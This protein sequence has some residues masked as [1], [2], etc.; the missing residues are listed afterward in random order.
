MWEIKTS[1]EGQNY[2]S[3]VNEFLLVDSSKDFV[4]DYISPWKTMQFYLE[5]IHQIAIIYEMIGDGDN[6]LSLLKWGKHI[7][8]SHHFPL[9]MVVFSS[10]LG[11][12][13]IKMGESDTAIE[14]LEYAL[15]I[16]KDNQKSLGCFK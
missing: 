7:S 1:D 12:L 10:L 14:E 3:I 5:A 6:A 15:K 11:K 16:F 4:A 2:T 8:C 13:Y 9:F